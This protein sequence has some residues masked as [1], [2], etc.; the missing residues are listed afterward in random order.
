MRLIKN[1]KV[2]HMLLLAV[3]AVAF[4]GVKVSN[5]AT[6]E[7]GTTEDPVVSQSYVDAKIT[8]L[9]TKITDLK[10]QLDSISQNQPS[11]ESK[12]EVLGPISAGKQIIAGESTEIVLRGGEATAIA[13][14]NGGVADLISGVDLRTGEKV[15]LNHLLLVSRNDGRGVLVTKEAW[16]MIRGTYSIK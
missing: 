13:S 14:T 3:I 5:A 1:V 2:V 11:K 16:I 4:I 10:K 7:P 6:S 15:P 8:E 12:Y 9:N